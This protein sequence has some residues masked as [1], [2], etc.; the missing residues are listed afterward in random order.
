MR[1]I[2]A[3]EH[4]ARQQQR[5]AGLPGMNFLAGHGIEIDTTYRLARLP[6]DIRPLIH[7]GRRLQVGPFTGQG[8]MRMPRGRAV[9]DHRHRQRRRMGGIVLD[10]HVQYRCQPSQALRANA[11][12]I[13]CIHDLKAQFFNTILWSTGAELV[14]IYRGHQ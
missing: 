10:L 9:G 8:E 4:G 12:A 1:R 11:S 14:N 5:F 13:R 7:I 3:G 6:A 2:P